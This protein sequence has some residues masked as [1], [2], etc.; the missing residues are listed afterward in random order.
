MA[1]L[2]ASWRGSLVEPWQQVCPYRP[3]RTMDVRLRQ[4]VPRTVLSEPCGLIVVRMLPASLR[5]RS[6][7]AVIAGA[8][9]LALMLA[10]LG[11]ALA[12]AV[13]GGEEIDAAQPLVLLR[14]LRRDA[15]RPIASSPPRTAY[16]RQIA[17]F[18]DLWRRRRV[19]PVKRYALA[20]DWRNRNGGNKL[21]DLAILQLRRRSWASRR[22]R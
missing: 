13:V 15:G 18:E 22:C 10:L 17:A 9:L 5:E 12:G 8:A 3:R 7:N 11:P 6:S 1:F 21:D 2:G 20:P 4:A 19:H 14:G 16:G